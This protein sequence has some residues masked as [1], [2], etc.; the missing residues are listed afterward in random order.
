MPYNDVNGRSV[1]LALL[2]QREGK[3]TTV[4]G[5]TKSI[6][7]DVGKVRLRL[8]RNHK[9][10]SCNINGVLP[11]VKGDKLWLEITRAGPDLDLTMDE[12]YFG[13][14]LFAPLGNA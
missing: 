13:G 14:W 4:L 9:H 5:C 7:L 10:K 11:V 1:S 2:H 3:I 8:G 12:I 6:E